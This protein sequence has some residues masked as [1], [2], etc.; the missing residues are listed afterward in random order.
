MDDV[1]VA[2]HDPPAGAHDAQAEVGVFAVRAGEALVEPAHGGERLPP[3]GHVR[4]GPLRVLQARHVALP[5]GGAIGHGHDDP[6]LGR[7]GVTRGAQV[8]FQRGAPV[9]RRQHVV[10]EERHPF[11]T[12]ARQPTLRAAAGPRAGPA[13]TRTPGGA[14]SG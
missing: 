2:A 7:A 1:T 13:T 12:A 10:V 11:G 6:A 3:V 8:A 9:V 4:G 5:V 14:G